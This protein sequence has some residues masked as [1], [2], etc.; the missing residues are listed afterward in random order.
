MSSSTYNYIVGT[1]TI[2]PDTGNIL[3]DVQTVYEDVFGTDL[4]TT[5]D[6]PQGVLI[7][8]EALAEAAVAAN[9]AQLANQI[10]P[11][12]AGGT[13]LDSLLALTGVQ[14]IAQTQTLVTNVTVAGV[15]G[16]IIPAGSQAQTAA[17]DIFI[18]AAQVTIPSGGNILVNFYSQAYG[19][20]PCASTD[21]NQV[22]SSVLGWET[23]NNNGSGSPPS[24][25]TL[26]MATQS[27]QQAR[28]FRQN[29]LAFQGI[30][31]AA[32]ITSS[33]YATPGVTS[34][35]FLENYH[36]SPAGMLI[37]ITGGSTLSGE[38]WGMTT[39][40]GT[41][42]NNTITVGTDAMN[43]A[44]S[45]QDLP[46]V[47]P[48]PIAA[49]GTIGNVT[50]S[51]LGTQGGGDWS[52]SLT[53]GQIIIVLANTTA[54]QNGLWIA[55]SGAW[56]RHPYNT[57]GQTIQPSIQGI[58]LI[59][60]SVYACVNGGTSTAVAAALLE[61]KS[62]GAAWN[63]NTPVTVVEPASRQ[64]Y[65]VLYDTPT[66]VEILVKVTTT[67]G[68]AQNITQAILDYVAGLIQG[69]AG[70]I[71]GASV[72]PFEIAQA[73]GEQYPQYFLSN[74]QISLT[75]PVSYANA[76]IPIGQNEIALT[77]ISDITI[78]VT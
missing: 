58:S 4:V 34:L 57:A 16:T 75:S 74:V 23:V 65:T 26:G 1:G 62:S 48:W 61:N 12:I 30:S 9:N 3:S 7:T 27:D 2:V 52:V 18:T 72:S 13:F 59:R 15:S 53:A 37:S 14:R 49:Y 47:N 54:S 36:S 17:G 21:L 60:N 10:N 38:I 19:A 45:L 31:L 29:T 44:E 64:S 40:T 22:V 68:N 41:G 78:V 39:T 5:P 56:T 67:N 8:T 32:A 42:L 25:T 69:Y 11:N 6:T 43:F 70:Y 50:L 20:I 66:T 73:I 63:G 46:A 33:L 35:S 28:A 51:G 55:A 71:V 77:S 24:V 76:V